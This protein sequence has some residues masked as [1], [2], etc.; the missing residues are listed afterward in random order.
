MG[1]GIFSGTINQMLFNRF[2]RMREELSLTHNLYQAKINRVKAYTDIQPEV[3]IPRVSH[4][5]FA[6]KSDLFKAHGVHASE[7]SYRL[8]KNKSNVVCEGETC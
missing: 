2:T 1:G 4:D 7:I 3:K 8:W 6:P 5:I